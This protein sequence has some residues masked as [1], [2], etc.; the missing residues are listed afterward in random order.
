VKV[1]GLVQSQIGSGHFVRMKQIQKGL[2]NKHHYMNLQHIQGKISHEDMAK[3]IVGQM[4]MIADYKPDVLLLEGFPFMRYAWYE[5]HNGILEI[6]KL[7]KNMKCYIV[8][9]VRDIAIPHNEKRA[10]FAVE[11]LNQYMDLVLVHGD[12]NFIKLEDSFPYTDLIDV[13]LEYTGYITDLYKPNAKVQRHGVLVSGASGAVADLVF[14]KALEMYKQS[15]KKEP[16]TFIISDKHPSESAK[17]FKKYAKTKKDI[18]IVSDIT[19]RDFRKLL[20]KSRLSISQCGYNTFLDS[21]I[22]ETP[23]TFIPFT[24]N[25]AISADQPMRTERYDNG[26]INI[27]ISGVEN[28]V[29]LLETLCC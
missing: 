6:L 1:Y 19:S 29:Q 20:V 16:W 27:N 13:P 15:T 14:D 12:K 26:N 3:R 9:S 2:R 21:Y 17:K 10:A 28:T 23:T 22:T 5:E 24:D 25:G 18:K 11:M 7:A 4:E 8:S